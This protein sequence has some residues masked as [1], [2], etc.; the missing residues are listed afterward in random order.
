MLF[1]Y[2]LFSSSWVLTTQIFGPSFSFLILFLIITFLLR[3]ISLLHLNEDISFYLY[4]VSV[5]YFFSLLTFFVLLFVTDPGIQHRNSSV[6]KDK[7][8]DGD[9][10]EDGSLIQQQQIK[11]Y[12]DSCAM[13][14]KDLKT[15]HCYDCQYC[16]QERHHHCEWLG[17]CIGKDNLLIYQIF[18]V[19]WITGL[20]YVFLIFSIFILENNSSP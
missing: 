13:F 4:L 12:C 7:T 17:K 19:L 9:G 20:F 11:R 5:F 3:L 2:E 14:Q 15:F 18:T 16:I 10:E 1:S 6:I 8:N